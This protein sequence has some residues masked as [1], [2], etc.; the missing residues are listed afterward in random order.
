MKF[1]NGAMMIFT[2]MLIASGLVACDNSGPA[3][4]MG[5]KI[6][7]ATDNA[8]A[9]ISD[10]ADKTKQKMMDQEKKV[11]TSLND[12]EITIKIKAILLNEKNI[13]SLKVGVDTNKGIVTLTG[14]IDTEMNRAKVIKIVE[15]V[16]GVSSVN[17]KNLVVSK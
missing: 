12:S 9:S 16:E 11:E 4:K 3:E 8:A 6:D 10:T 14:F 5:K 17:S 7:Q 2:S 15:S 13:N 1:K